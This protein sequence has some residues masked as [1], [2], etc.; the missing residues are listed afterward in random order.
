MAFFSVN[1]MRELGS[2]TFKACFRSHSYFAR[3]LRPES[4]DLVLGL[5]SLETPVN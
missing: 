5:V 4:Y 3:D 2:E 1:E